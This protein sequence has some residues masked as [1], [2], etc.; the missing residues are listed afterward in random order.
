ML[1]FNDKEIVEDLSYQLADRNMSCSFGQS[2]E[3]IE[4]MP[5]GKCK[6]TLEQR[7]L[8]HRRHGALLRRPG[9]G[10]GDAG[11]GGSRSGGRQ[12]RP[13]Q[14]QSRD[15]SRPRCPTSMPP[16]TC[17]LSLAR[18]DFDGAGRIAARHAVG[19]AACDSAAIF[20]LRHL[21]RAGDFTCGLT[22]EEVK[23][24]NIPYECGICAVRETSRGHIMGLENGMLKMIFSLK[25]RR[26]LGIHII[27][28]G[29]PNWSISARPSSTSKERSITSSRTP[30]IIRPRR[31]LQ[32]RRAGCWNRMANCPNRPASI[33]GGPVTACLD[34][35]D[36]E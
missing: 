3:R 5:D 8:A 34:P 21:C 18:I 22:E 16:A 26:L 7:P 27:G 23:A 29:A 17:G 33:P 36:A 1:D 30:S 14:G 19:A 25:T 2:A 9:R 15:L 4:H 28:E 35:F 32:D 6:V 24:R 20:S 13:H 31:S 12:P 10:G 11:S